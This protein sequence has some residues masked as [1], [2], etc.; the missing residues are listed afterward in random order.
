MYYCNL[1]LDITN[2]YECMI[3]GT[4]NLKKSQGV[5]MKI[6]EIY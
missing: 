5:V 6:Y 2:M 3:E 1:L 4:K